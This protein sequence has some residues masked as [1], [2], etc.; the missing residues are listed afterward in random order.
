MSNVLVLASSSASRR[1]MLESAG[2]LFTV[3]VP[4]V[5]EDLLKALLSDAGKDGDGIAQELAD[6]KALN[7]SRHLPNDYVLGADQLLICDGQFFSKADTEQKARDTL[8]ALSGRQHRLISAA[9]IARDGVM[10]WRRSDAALLRMRPL[11]A[12]FLDQYLAA[13]MPEI[14]GSVGCYR[15]E[16]RGAQLFS[17]VSGDHFSIRGLPLIPVLGALRDF[18]VISI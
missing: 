9:V 16:G 6:A 2:V 13:E 11:S 14:L 8:E 10:L 17:E 4:A 12:D 1:T 18:G 15:I 3:A 7:V 5:D